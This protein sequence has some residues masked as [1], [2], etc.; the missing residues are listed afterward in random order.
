MGRYEWPN[1]WRGDPSPAD[2]PYHHIFSKP[3]PP[4]KQAFLD[5][6]PADNPVT[7]G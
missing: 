6:H 5:S 1:K 3:P 2:T 4:L 7:S